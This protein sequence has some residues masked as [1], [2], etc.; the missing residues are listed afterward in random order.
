MKI[1]HG[2]VVM[3]LSLL[4]R[5]L[6]I[7]VLLVVLPPTLIFLSSSLSINTVGT[8]SEKLLEYISG[9]AITINEDASSLSNCLRIKYGLATV[10]SHNV[11][12][13]T[14][15]IVVD[16][17]MK[18][19][20]LVIIDLGTTRDSYGYAKISVSPALVKVLDTS[21]G[22]SLKI[23]VSNEC[24]NAYVTYSHR[25]KLENFLIAEDTNKSIGLADGFLCVRDARDVGR[26]I[27]DSLI[28]ELAIFSRSYVLLVFLVYTPILYLADIKLLE[29]LSKELKILRAEGLSVSDL[30]LVFV[31]STSLVTG[32]VA[33]YSTALSYLIVSAGITI[34]RDLFNP[35]IPMPELSVEYVTLAAIITPLNLLVSYVVFRLGGHDVIS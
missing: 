10:I 27:I 32:I 34:L 25:G 12:L 15:V 33:L 11:S 28:K 24:F 31:L 20:D 17:V 4:R 3:F 26:L 30:C 18:L 22:E 29:E 8:F 1:R 5:R 16:E 7:V 23:C 13:R 21:L 6:T 35:M 14:Q 9:V 19:R 2:F